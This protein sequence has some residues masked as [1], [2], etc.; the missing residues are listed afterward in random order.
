MTQA[1]SRMETSNEAEPSDEEMRKLLKPAPTTEQVL[2]AIQK[3]YVGDEGPTTVKL[4]RELESYDDRNYW[5]EIS[6]T[7]YLVKVHNGVESKD[8][9]RLWKEES[10]HERS[11][12]HLQNALMEHLCSHGISTSKPVKPDPKTNP[13]S[14]LPTAA[15]IHALPVVSEKHSPCD[16]VVRLLHWVPG[17]TM[18]SKKLLPLE[19]LVDVGRFLGNLSN[20]LNLLD[21]DTLPASKRY[22]QWDG[23]NTSD[24]KNF[25]QYIKDDGKRAMVE[26]ILNAFQE[27][28]IGSGVSE[29]FEKALIHGDFNDAN[30]LVD[31]DFMISGVLDFGDS[32][33]R[34]AT[35][36]FYSL[37]THFCVFYGLE[38]AHFKTRVS[39]F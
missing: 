2:D 35:I 15:T 4:V 19:T 11:V 28:I 12:I 24:L 10:A 16:L 32:V 38:K 14:A 26:S 36:D 17:S 3:S 5:V 23:R 7:P 34:Y 29:S 27:E 6:G 37:S 18:E 20:K 13:G 33:E 21:A 22:H 8:F 25:T 30:V 9:I 31:D 1:T 39:S